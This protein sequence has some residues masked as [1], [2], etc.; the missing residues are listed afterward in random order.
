MHRHALT[1]LVAVT[2]IAGL[3]FI[4]QSTFKTYTTI[5]ATER[6]VSELRKTLDTLTKQ[7]K[8]VE[9]ALTPEQITELKKRARAKGANKAQLAREFKI[10]RETLYQYTRRA[11]KK[12]RSAA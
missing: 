3:L 8:A 9:T 1:V 6:D 5:A 10:S 7:E 11:P 4:A 12:A 2:S